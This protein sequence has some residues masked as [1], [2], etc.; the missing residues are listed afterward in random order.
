[1]NLQNFIKCLIKLGPSN[2]FHESYDQETTLNDIFTDIYKKYYSC[3]GNG[4][5]FLP[6]IKIKSTEKPPNFYI[7]SENLTKTIQQAYKDFHVQSFIF[8]APRGN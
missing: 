3:L 6:I 2:S 1:M 7:L 8:P 4:L 5:D